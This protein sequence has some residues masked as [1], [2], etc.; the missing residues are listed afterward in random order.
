MTQFAWAG[1]AFLAFLI[2]A[3]G[4]SAFGLWW[5]GEVEDLG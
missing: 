3:C 2:A 4:F 5:M 1:L